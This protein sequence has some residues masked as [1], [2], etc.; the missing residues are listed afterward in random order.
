M[1]WEYVE[2]N[3]YN[4]GPELY[5]DWYDDDL[6]F[7][8]IG[9]S[10]SH[11]AGAGGSGLQVAGVGGYSIEEAQM[12][13][14]SR[15]KRKKAIFD[16]YDTDELDSLKGDEN[17]GEIV[18]LPVFNEAVEK[19]Q[20]KLA[21]REWVA[22]KLVPRVR[23]Q[24]SMTGDEAYDYLMHLYR[25]KVGD[26]MIYRALCIAHKTC[27]GSEKEQYTKL[28]DYCNELLKSNPGSSV[29][30]N[31]AP[32]SHHFQRMPLIGL[33]GC[34]LKEYFGGQLLSAVAQDA[35]NA[36]YVIAY[37]IVDVENTENWRWFLINLVDDLGN[38]VLNGFSF[39][40]DMQNGLDAALKE[41]C[42]GVPHRFCARHI[43]ANF[44]KNWPATKQQFQ[45]RMDHLKTISP[46]GWLW[47]SKLPPGRWTKSAFDT[48]SK[49]DSLTNNMCEQFNSEIMKVRSKPII[50]MVEGIRMYIMKKMTMSKLQ[51]AKYKGEA[52]ASQAISLP[53]PVPDSLFYKEDLQSIPLQVNSFILNFILGYVFVDLTRIVL[54]IEVVI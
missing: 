5:L 40:S 25:V 28:R 16:A 26:T 30:L 35:N 53:V 38:P 37:A 6:E 20:N 11:D 3:G 1:A 24:P 12:Q 27:Q 15:A 36:F 10:T 9:G 34:F 31:V 50:T 33:D 42:P 44:N 7:I 43:W 8:A 52:S 47:L 41:I 49:N 45:L 32:V 4:V 39:M 21:T 14:K 48:Y 17:D 18:Q 23:L 13:D 51:M 54:L 46:E 29:G 19:L 22:S 2:D